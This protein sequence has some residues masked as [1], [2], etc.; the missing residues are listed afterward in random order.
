MSMKTIID[1]LDVQIWDGLMFAL[2]G[3][4]EKERRS[5]VGYCSQQSVGNCESCSLVNYDKD[6]HNNQIETGLT[7][8][9]D[10]DCLK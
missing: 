2:P 6:C 4:T 9:T 7:R 3:E 5:L 10:G 1:D 8:E